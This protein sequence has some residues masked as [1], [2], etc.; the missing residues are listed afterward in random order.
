MLL[1]IPRGFHTRKAQAQRGNRITCHGASFC[2]FFLF[3]G[4]T[5][6]WGGLQ[7]HILH[8]IFSV[9]DRKLHAPGIISQYSFVAEIALLISMLR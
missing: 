1:Q 9:C 2:L 4:E 8:D 6:I 7:F 5:C 3:D